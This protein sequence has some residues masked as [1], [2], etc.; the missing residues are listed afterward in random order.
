MSAKLLL[1]TGHSFNKYDDLSPANV[2]V[3]NIRAKASGVIQLFKVR[4]RHIFYVM[5][6]KG[7][8]ITELS[9]RCPVFVA[10]IVWK[11][12]V[13][14]IIK[15][16]QMDDSVSSF[17]QRGRIQGELDFPVQ[18]NPCKEKGIHICLEQ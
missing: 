2:H 14:L 12:R 1:Q 4:H 3:R 15:D 18:R 10:G 6:W 5:F 11:W 16:K 17:T 8:S 13:I 9:P 7:V